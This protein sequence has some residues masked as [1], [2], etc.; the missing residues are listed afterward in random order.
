MSL[1]SLFFAFKNAVKNVFRNTILSLASIT[2]LT[3]C[4]IF[5]GSML[6]ILMNV[7]AFLDSVGDENQIVVYLE[8]D[9]TPEQIEAAG[10]SLSDISNVSSV[11]YESPEQALENY[12]Q[13]LGDS[14]LT[15]GLDPSVFRPSYI[16]EIVDL[17][18][19][20]QTVYEIE[21]VDQIGYFA[22]GERAIR[23]PYEFVDKLVSIRQ[24]MSFMGICIVAIFLVTSVFI[25]TNSVKLSV[26]SRK[27]EIYIMRYVGASDFYIQLPYFI[28]GMLIGLVSGVLGYLIEL[29]LYNSILAPLMTD[30]GLFDPISISQSFGYMPL[31]F[32]LVGLLVG[33]IGSVVPV[34]RYLSV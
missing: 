10:Q 6:L 1:D 5:L 7:N 17:S 25:I 13:I 30:L 8:E 31:C 29:G 23:S 26:F 14:S 16:I 2:V 24:I 19:F 20:D 15:E 22:N 34:K 21:K 9:S 12:S 11:K 3:V 32:I 27:D 33:I 18:K 28:E 4:L